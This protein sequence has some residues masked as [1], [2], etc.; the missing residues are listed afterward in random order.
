MAALWSP[1]TG[2]VDS[3]QLVRSLDQAAVEAG[4]TIALGHRYRSAEPSGRGFVVRCLD[5]RGQELLVQSRIV[6]N[7]AGLDADL[8]AQSVGIDVTAAGYRQTFVK[9]SYCR[10][11][12]GSGPRI[13]HLVYPVPHQGLTG[14]GVHATVDIAGGVRFGPDVE[15]LEGRTAD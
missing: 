8:V 6:V 2:I 12:E 1:N 3:H 5:P 13:R 15:F 7:A 14:L 9:G 11:A 10:L 4:A